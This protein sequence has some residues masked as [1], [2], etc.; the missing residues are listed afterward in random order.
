MIEFSSSPSIEVGGD[1]Y[2]GAGLHHHVVPVEDSLSAIIVHDSVC[3]GVDII[4]C[5]AH[6][7]PGE[8]AQ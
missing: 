7:Q 8:V 2:E 5:C 3:A 4:F 1:G 6:C